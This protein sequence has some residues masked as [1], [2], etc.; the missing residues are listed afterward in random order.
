[1][2]LPPAPTQRASR[3]THTA[4]TT[5][6][7]D[8]NSPGSA[9]IQI[10]TKAP[11]AATPQAAPSIQAVATG[12]KLA[13]SPTAASTTKKSASPRKS[14]AVVTPSDPTLELAKAAAQAGKTRPVPAAAA[15]AQ[16]P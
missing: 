9:M 8:D 4:F 10:E 15:R 16:R 6:A 14:S 1:M 12:Q 3:L 2:P 11:L 13:T 7:G 5:A